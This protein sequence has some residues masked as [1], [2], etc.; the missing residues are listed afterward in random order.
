MEK[1]NKRFFI[2]YLSIIIISIISFTIPPFFIG[3]NSVGMKYLPIN[4]FF[5]EMVYNFLFLS[6]MVIISG[7][8][9]GY[10]ISPMMLILHKKIIGRKYKFGFYKQ[11]DSKDHKNIF[12]K[13]IFP[14]LMATNLAIKVSENLD[15]RAFITNLTPIEDLNTQ[16]I[17][18]IFLLPLMLILCIPL[19]T[20]VWFLDNSRIIFTNSETITPGD[21]IKIDS[22]S[23][24]YMNLLKGFTGISTII[25]FGQLLLEILFAA[26]SSQDYGLLINPPTWA[27]FPLGLSLLISP[28]F[29]L[30]NKTKEVRKKYLIKIANKLGI[31]EVI[32]VSIE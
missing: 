6:I 24:Y 8:C 16:M 7:F 1:K 4:N 27:L 17:T 12:F 19:F 2:L 30:L 28:L 13:G 10:I 11:G 14:A 26:I 20:S 3:N 21:L 5:L 29:V 32:N 31:K 23:N 22:S 25:V 15:V 9:L 18:F